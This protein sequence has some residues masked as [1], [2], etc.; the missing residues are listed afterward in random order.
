MSS[1]Q[2][3]QDFNLFLENNTDEKDIVLNGCHK[4]QD[5]NKIFETDISNASVDDLSSMIVSQ[6]ITSVKED[7]NKNT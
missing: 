4:T 6:M 3:N 2:T 7:L 1:I 5:D